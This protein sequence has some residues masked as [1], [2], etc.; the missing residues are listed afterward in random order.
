MIA[1]TAMG[2][3]LD[4]LSFLFEIQI[5]TVSKETPVIKIVLML[6]NKIVIAMFN[7]NIKSNQNALKKKQLAV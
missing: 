7:A 2:S 4:S 6:L 3:D 1:A 5:F